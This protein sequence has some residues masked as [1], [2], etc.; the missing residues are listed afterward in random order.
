[1]VQGAKIGPCETLRFFNTVNNFGYF[2]K[3]HDGEESFVTFLCVKIFWHLIPK[4]I[5]RIDES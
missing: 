1:M 5:P 4:K 3:L 2:Q